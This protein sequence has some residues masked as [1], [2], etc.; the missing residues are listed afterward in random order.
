MKTF[1]ILIF[2]VLL[3]SM[4]L[5]AQNNRII[6]AKAGTKITD[7]YPYNERFLYPE[8]VPGQVFFKNGTVNTVNL[9]YFYITGEIEF[10]Q[11][12]DTMFISK[13]KDLLNV[14]A[15]DTFYFDNGYIRVL[16]GG[17]IKLGLK[18]Y[19]KLKDVLK[20]GAM[21]TVNRVSSID[22]FNSV[23]AD[24]NSFGLI[25]NENIEVQMTLEYYLFKPDNGFVHFNKKNVQQ[26]FPE[27]SDKIKSYIKSNKVN[28]DSRNDLMKF[29]DFL[30]SL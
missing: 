13:K 11:G 9:N 14:V 5:S 22:T 27:Y 1:T 30:R 29:T 25:P 7:Y 20:E 2:S 17:E 21:G 24:G 4:N 18:Q 12:T 26:L 28:F 15:Q 3:F 10:L 16:S 19:V 23:W 8:F 6:L